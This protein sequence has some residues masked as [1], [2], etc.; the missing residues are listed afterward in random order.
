VEF[1]WDEDKRKHN[2]LKHG[3]DFKDVPNAFESRI[4]E[5]LDTRKEYGEDRWVCFGTIR[6]TVVVIVFTERSEDL[7]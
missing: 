3:V 2:L 6:A 5:I 7:F 4:L 1:E